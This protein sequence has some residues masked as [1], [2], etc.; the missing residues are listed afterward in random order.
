METRSF[1]KA[2]LSKKGDPDVMMKV[3]TSGDTFSP[4]MMDAIRTLFTA[5]LSTADLFRVPFSFFFSDADT[6]ENGEPAEVPKPENT[7]PTFTD[8]ITIIRITPLNQDQVDKAI[9][10]GDLT[11]MNCLVALKNL[12]DGYQSAIMEYKHQI[13]QV[14]QFKDTTTW[15]LQKLI[16]NRNMETDD[17]QEWPETID[18]KL[19]QKYRRNKNADVDVS[20]VTF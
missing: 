10:D 5:G 8:I 13:I 20:C 15:I 6:D 19:P 9:L 18:W 12:T 16:A 1:Y 2:F 17:P 14:F 4:T 11:R 7:E 3:D